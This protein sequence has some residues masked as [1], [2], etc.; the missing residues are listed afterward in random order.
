M[1][2]K[3]S[4]YPFIFTVASL[5]FISGA[6]AQEKHSYSHSAA[7]PSPPTLGAE[8]I[9]ALEG[10]YV[11]NIKQLTFEG[12]N[13]E[14]YF[15]PDEKRIIFQAV[16]GENPFYQIYLMDADGGN[17][18]RVST[19]RGKTTCAF[20]HPGSEKIIYA[21]THLDPQAAAKEEEARRR[22]AS[23]EDRR[24]RYEWDFDEHFDVFEANPDGSGLRRLTD[25]SGYDAECSYSHDGRKIC[26]TSKRD[27]DAEIY[28]MDAD[29]RNPKRLT[30]HE[31]YDGGP[32]FM[33]GDARIVFRRFT[34]DG[35]SCNVWVMDADGGNPRQLSEGEAVSW[36]PY[37]HPGGEH[38]L[39][40]SNVEGHR[41]FEI[42]LIRADGAGTKTRLT[43]DPAADVLPVFSPGGR[44]M[45]W[46]STRRGGESQIFAADFL[47]PELPLLPARTPEI[48]AGEILSHLSFLASDALGGRRTG[49]LG[50]GAAAA[51]IASEFQKYGLA[52]PEGPADYFQPFSFVESL[53]A[54]D[55]NRITL[56][57]ESGNLILKQGVDY[58]PLAFSSPGETGG[59]L[60][61]AGYGIA[62]EDPAYDSYKGLD[63]KGKVVV[64]LARR[65]DYRNPH[66]ALDRFAAPRYKVLAARERGAAGLLVVLGPESAEEDRLEALETDQSLQDSGIPA[67][68]IGRAVAE[69]LFREA[70]KDLRETQRAL[71]ALDGSEARHSF[72]FPKARA[73]M[74]CRVERRQGECRNVVGLLPPAGTETV[75]EW[76]VVGAHYDH[77]GGGVKGSL[78]PDS[79]EVHN[80]ADDNASGT[81]GLLELA[82]A[83][84]AEPN[85]RRGIVFAAFSGEEMGLLGS[86]HFVEHPP[87]PLGEIAAMLNFDMIGRL[88][89]DKLTVQGT[90]ASTAWKPLLDEAQRGSGLRFSYKE[91]GYGPSDSTSFYAK[92]IPVLFFFTGAHDDYHKPSD[93]VER[94]RLAGME[95]VLRSAHGVLRRMVNLD[96]RPD[97]V[98]TKGE[99]GER[100]QAVMRVYL[101]T[102]PDYTEEVEGVKLTGVREGG[103]A[104]E[105]GL[106]G[107]DVIVELAGRKITNVYDYTYALQELKADEP[108]EIVVRRGAETLQLKITPKLR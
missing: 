106:R 79:H 54:P 55:G 4:K 85:R 27:G 21:S 104:Q 29:G 92:E 78:A 6:W 31:G 25:S 10:R 48:T 35:A 44:K 45:M 102:V 17:V 74:R 41:N 89:D 50:A 73:R 70:G 60:V 53:H 40:T 93:D 62:S 76:V 67:A 22:A 33:P 96:A 94:I 86:A 18:R 23:G 8:E 7:A 99:P 64:V 56:R 34:A 103:P 42:F 80:G 20:F 108:V 61:F 38:L 107:G 26:F 66:S 95:K 24:R 5:S 101:G 46:T 37:P 28:V 63:V 52:A 15:S 105:A 3:P 58:I 16:R 59:G 51:H 36:A 72:A 32:F 11:A 19:G 39:Y 47:D 81:A 13:G 90:G 77:L 88:R 83:M 69:K 43:F 2:T 84:A 68:A 91:D 97:Y 9:E 30:F 75:D 98:R 100:E 14:A 49:S 71:D 65:P 87:V 57:T 12:K 82:Q 1:R